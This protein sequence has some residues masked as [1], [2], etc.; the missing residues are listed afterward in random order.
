MSTYCVQGPL[1]DALCE[2]FYLI[3]ERVNMLFMEMK[4][5]ECNM[6]LIECCK[7]NRYVTE[8]MMV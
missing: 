2:L 5:T 8:W 3:D 1:I 7:Y 6:W 4:V